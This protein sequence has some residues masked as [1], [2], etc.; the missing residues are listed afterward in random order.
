MHMALDGLRWHRMASNIVDV[1]RSLC[2]VCAWWFGTVCATI[3][4]TRTAQARE[5]IE[6]GNG[7]PKAERH[8]PCAASSRTGTGAN[9][10]ARR[11]GLANEGP[12]KQK[13]KWCASSLTAREQNSHSRG[14]CHRTRRK[15]SMHTHRTHQASQETLSG[16]S[17]SDR[18]CAQCALS[19]PLS[20][21]VL[22]RIPTSSMQPNAI[23][24]RCV[25]VLFEGPILQLSRNE[26][27]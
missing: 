3:D 24:C 4:E 25:G 5:T 12:S 11:R 26:R 13:R 1:R 18:S 6:G 8:E 10:S 27:C 20:A 22:R 14:Q 17:S 7:S 21:C 2:R 9:R 23:L 16:M 15:H 19:E